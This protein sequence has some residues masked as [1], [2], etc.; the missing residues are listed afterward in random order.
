MKFQVALENLGKNADFKMAAA[1]EVYLKD[2]RGIFP[3]LWVQQE[4][5]YSLEHE[6]CLLTIV[7]LLHL[8]CTV[9]LHMTIVSNNE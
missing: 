5:C 4:D 3:G 9:W 7:T 1:A 2:K 8:L 6:A